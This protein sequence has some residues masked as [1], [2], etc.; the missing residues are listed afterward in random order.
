MLSELMII[1]QRY[2][3]FLYT[4]NEVLREKRERCAANQQ[5]YNKNPIEKEKFIEEN[6]F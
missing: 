2:L 1:L 5:D 3:L 6:Y 4:N